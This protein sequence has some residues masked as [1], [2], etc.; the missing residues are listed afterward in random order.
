V[1]YELGADVM[2]DLRGF[3]RITLKPGETRT[4]SF[5]LAATSLAYWDEA[6][7]AWVVENAP[8]S[9]EVG[10]SSADIRARRTIKVVG[11]K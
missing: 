8:V 7:H 5:P 2:C 11:T 9:L 3:K 6:T 1:H 4:V 10:A